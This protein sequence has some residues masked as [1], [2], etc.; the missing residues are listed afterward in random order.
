MFGEKACGEKWN[1]Q[2]CKIRLSLR[3]KTNQHECARL[4]SLMLAG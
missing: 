3:D 1:R 4:A 2:L